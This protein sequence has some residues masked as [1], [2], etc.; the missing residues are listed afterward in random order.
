MSLSSPAHSNLAASVVCQLWHSFQARDWAGARALLIDRACCDWVASGERLASADTII[1]ANREYPEGWTL[2]LLAVNVLLD[3]RVHS[4]IRVEHGSAIFF[5]NTLFTVTAE[6][7]IEHM[8]EYWG[9][10]EAPPA[11]RLQ[12]GWPDYTVTPLS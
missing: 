12:A 4:I 11:S 5:A 7:L 3:G 9:T 8:E 10:A 2:H 1:R 6:G